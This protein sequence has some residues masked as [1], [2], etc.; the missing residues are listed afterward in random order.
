V[1][2]DRDRRR[3]ITPPAGVRV[4]TAPESW[5]GGDS[6]T[7][8][9]VDGPTDP[10]D[11]L[12]RINRRVKLTARTSQSTL[13][14]VGEMR[15]AFDGQVASLTQDLYKARAESA[16]NGGKL[17]ILLSVLEAERKE[18]QQFTQISAAAYQAGVDVER[19]RDMSQI[20]LER[21]TALSVITER[22]E[23]ALYRRQILLKVLAGIATLWGTIA[24][25]V[26]AR[27]G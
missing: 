11:T 12:D 24:T 21:T 18:R 14:T 25:I 13:D 10:A 2:T 19:A 16:A 22:K 9:P 6:H 23:R 3:I 1:T 4:Q 8:P 15:R 7:P 26:L 17:D 20:D 27:R 5:E